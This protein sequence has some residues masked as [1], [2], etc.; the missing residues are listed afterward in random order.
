MHIAHTKNSGMSFKFILSSFLSVKRMA[1]INGRIAIENLKNSNVVESIPFC[2]S[3]R[4]K[5]PLDPN[6]KPA[7]MGKIK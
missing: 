4:T 2:V 3:V 1:I 5:T 6:I 7:S